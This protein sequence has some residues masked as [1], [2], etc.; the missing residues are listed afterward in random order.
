M[1]AAGQVGKQGRWMGEQGG[2]A[3]MCLVERRWSAP[4]SCPI[5]FK[6]HTPLTM[7]PPNIEPFS[8]AEGHWTF[9]SHT[10]AFE[11]QRQERQRRTKRA[12]YRGLF[13]VGGGRPLFSSISCP[14]PAARTHLEG[15]DLCSERRSAKHPRSDPAAH[16][17]SCSD[18]LEQPASTPFS[19]SA[20]RRSER[21]RHMS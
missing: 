2:R 5:R 11:E 9:W 20:G 3:H 18:G 19:V 21:I 14:A 16:V 7:V 10:W 17:S 12:A 8:A 1:A 6:P 4:A 13:R 15:R